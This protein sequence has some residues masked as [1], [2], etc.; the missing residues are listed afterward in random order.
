[1]IS[2]FLVGDGVEQ[3]VKSGPEIDNTISDDQRPSFVVGLRTGHLSNEC[4][5]S[6]VLVATNTESVN[7]TFHP[8]M[9]LTLDTFE[10]LIGATKLGPNA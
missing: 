8:L 10:M 4:P 6:E 7:V 5:L 1:M 9:D 2:R 3:V